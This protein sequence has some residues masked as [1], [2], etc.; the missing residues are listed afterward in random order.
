MVMGRA[1][2][3]CTELFLFHV[4]TLPAWK[5]VPCVYFEISAGRAMCVLW[6]VL[7]DGRNVVCV[8]FGCFWASETCHVCTLG[9]GNVPCLYFAPSGR[10]VLCVYFGGGLRLARWS[11]L[12]W[13][14][15]GRRLA[16]S[17]PGPLRRWARLRARRP[18]QLATARAA[19]AGAGRLCAGHTGRSLVEHSRRGRGRRGVGRQRADTSARGQGRGR[20]R[21][22]ADK[23]RTAR[24]RRRIQQEKGG[25][26]LE[27]SPH[28][29]L[30]RLEA[31]GA[32]PD[33]A[34]KRQPN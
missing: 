10:N 15:R 29:P 2:H 28:T 16:R 9:F 26:P 5:N 18:M 6:C 14:A 8:Y 33:R 23:E 24:G 27:T 11:R 19:E 20:T 25:P 22:R 30:P 21:Q 7:L 4:C 13:S 34:I 32:G 12:W 17:R 31:R 1:F 3:V